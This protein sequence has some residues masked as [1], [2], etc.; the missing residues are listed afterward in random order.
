MTA[1]EDI[2]FAQ[3]NSKQ[4]FPGFERVSRHLHIRKT[5]T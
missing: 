4:D 2:C 1:F 3:E 5:E